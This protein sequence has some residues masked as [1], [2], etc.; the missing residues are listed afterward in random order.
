MSEQC[1]DKSRVEAAVRRLQGLSKQLERRDDDLRFAAELAAQGLI[2]LR[3]FG[4]VA[5]RTVTAG[6]FPVLSTAAGFL[7]IVPDCNVNL[8]H[9]S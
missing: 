5:N 6:S 8:A 2:C 9:S 7:D 1:S 4:K 3:A